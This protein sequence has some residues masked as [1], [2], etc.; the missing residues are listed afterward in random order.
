MLEEGGGVLSQGVRDRSKRNEAR[1]I[2]VHRG[3]RVV[4]VSVVNVLCSRPRET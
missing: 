4:W 2:R 3:G 1:N